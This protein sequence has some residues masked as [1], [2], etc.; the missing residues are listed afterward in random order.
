M[1]PASNTSPLQTAYQCQKMGKELE[2]KFMYHTVTI[3]SHFEGNQQQ[4]APENSSVQQ[5]EE[6]DWFDLQLYNLGTH[7]ATQGQ[8]ISWGRKCH[9]MLSQLKQTMEIVYTKWLFLLGNIHLKPWARNSGENTC[10]M[11][12]LI[13]L[14]IHFLAL[15]PPEWLTQRLRY[16][17]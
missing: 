6:R 14:D 13:A 11:T 5:D 8:G 1:S 7:L 3:P 10:K 15:H 9:L 4:G 2:T 16:E 17:Q 12:V